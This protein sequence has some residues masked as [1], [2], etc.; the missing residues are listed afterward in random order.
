ME[1]QSGWW[2]WKKDD[3]SYQYGWNDDDILLYRYFGSADYDADQDEVSKAMDKLTEFADGA[4]KFVYVDN[5]FVLKYAFSPEWMDED[6]L[7]KKLAEFEEFADSQEL[8]DFLA[9]YED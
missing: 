7:E 1:S 6:D 4:G 2:A 5:Y 8:A 9:K 3:A